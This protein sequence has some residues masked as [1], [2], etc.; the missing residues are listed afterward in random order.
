MLN[1]VMDVWNDVFSGGTNV[2]SIPSNPTSVLMAGSYDNYVLGNTALTRDKVETVTFANTITPPT[3]AIGSWDVSATQNGSVIA[4]Y[5][6]TDSNGLYELTIGGD[7]QVYANPNSSYLF[8]N[9]QSLKSMDTT[10]FNT[11][12]ATDMSQMFCGA[13]YSATT[14]NLNL[15]NWNIS[16]VT[17]MN[18]MFQST[19]KLQTLRLDNWATPTATVTNMFLNT[20]ANI[21]VYVNSAFNQAYLSGTGL[22]ANAFVVVP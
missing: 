8:Y 1:N 18:F 19:Q 13:G 6:D 15:S 9:Y 4:W 5:T 7:G 12:T 3:N 20:N 11:V 10:Y 17:N 14:F 16:K 2:D 22:P 21:K